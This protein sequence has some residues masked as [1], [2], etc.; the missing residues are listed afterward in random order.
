MGN[1]ESLSGLRTINP[2]GKQDWFCTPPCRGE[3][4]IYSR[5]YPFSAD[6]RNLA[7]N[8][9]R[10]HLVGAGKKTQGIGREPHAYQ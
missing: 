5:C 7:Y 1:R 4:A 2:S 6:R 9:E 3:E 8:Q 10:R